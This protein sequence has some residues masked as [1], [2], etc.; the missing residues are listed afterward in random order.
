MPPSHPPPPPL[1]APAPGGSLWEACGQDPYYHAKRG[2]AGVLQARDHAYREFRREVA[3]GRIDP[4]VDEY[5]TYLCTF[6]DPGSGRTIFFHTPW[7]KATF[8]A[9]ADGCHRHQARC[10][11]AETERIRIYT[12][13]HSH[14][15]RSPEGAGPSR[16]DVA[17][18]S[19][20]KNADGTYRHLY[21]INNGGRLLAFKARRDIDPGD[22]AALASLPHRPRRGVD[23]LD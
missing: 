6:E 7:L 12:L 18:A 8:L 17:T 9:T 14:P 10:P 20:F 21:L 11:V 1:T 15:T 13:M 5:F 19:R 4:S 3:A 23:W 2:F 22:R 16:V